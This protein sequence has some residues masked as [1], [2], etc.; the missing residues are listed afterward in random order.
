MPRSKDQSPETT[1]GTPPAAK[2]DT[3]PAQA[4]PATEKIAFIAPRRRSP[5]SVAF[6]LQIAANLNYLL[7]ILNYLLHFLN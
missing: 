2:A 1:A 5:R 6:F 7:H 4:R 3:R